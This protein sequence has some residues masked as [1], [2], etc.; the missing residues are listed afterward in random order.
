MANKVSV[1]CSRCSGSGQIA[2]STL[3]RSR[4]HSGA[5]SHTCGECGGSGTKWVEPNQ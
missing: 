1:N 2:I 5:T 3:D 4:D